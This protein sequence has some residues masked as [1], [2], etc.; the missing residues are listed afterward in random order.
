MSRGKAS[1]DSIPISSFMT[2]NLKAE[3]ADQSIHAA[4]KIMHK[5]NIGSVIVVK[6]YTTEPV[7]IITERDIVRIIGS[8]DISL[9]HLPLRE[10][11]SKPLISISPNSSIKDALQAMQLNKIRRLPV[12]KEGNVL[13]GII[14]DKDVFR[15]IMENQDLVASL[16]IEEFFR[17]NKPLLSHL[18]EHMFSNIFPPH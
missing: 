4:C 12:A 3:T 16:S 14:T 11:M 17:G 13:V 10:L 2:A 15:V 9:L 6:E 7:G 5:N 18:G 1:I 8:S